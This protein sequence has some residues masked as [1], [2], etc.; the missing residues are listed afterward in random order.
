MPTIRR[1]REYYL[2]THDPQKEM[3]SFLIT[4]R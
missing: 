3:E 2:T 4:D 1:T